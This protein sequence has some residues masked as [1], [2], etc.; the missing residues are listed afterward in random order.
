MWV[1]GVSQ[2]PRGQNSWHIIRGQYLH[3]HQKLQWS[4]ESNMVFVKPTQP[5]SSSHADG[6][7]PICP[8]TTQDSLCSVARIPG[9]LCSPPECVKLELP[10]WNLEAP[11]KVKLGTDNLLGPD[12]PLNQQLERYYHRC[13][14]V[15]PFPW[16]WV[17]E[18]QCSSLGMIER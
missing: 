18:G 10:T 12:P 15:Q 17:F 2:F 16:V 13:H 7:A 3:E 5:N 11:H 8:Y 9:C 4:I 14:C 6:Q 1:S